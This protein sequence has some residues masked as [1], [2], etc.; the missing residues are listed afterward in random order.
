MKLL[1][2]GIKALEDVYQGPVIK[3]SELISTSSKATLEV[4]P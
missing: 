3:L 1:P 4:R 2:E